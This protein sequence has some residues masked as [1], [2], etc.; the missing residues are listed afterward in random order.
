[1]N[2][3]LTPALLGDGFAGIGSTFAAFGFRAIA[4]RSPRRLLMRLALK[5]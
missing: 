1:M 5:S 3:G 4:R 2:G